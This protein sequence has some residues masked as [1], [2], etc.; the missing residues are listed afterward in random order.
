M[1]SSV[2]LLFVLVVG[3]IPSRGEQVHTRKVDEEWLQKKPLSLAVLDIHT[4]ENPIDPVFLQM[5]L[6]QALRELGYSET[7][8]QAYQRPQKPWKNREAAGVAQQT[9]HDAALVL[10]FHNEE[11]LLQASL[12]VI[13]T[14]GTIR[15]DVQLELSAEGLTGEDLILKLLSPLERIL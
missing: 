15:Y 1:K 12:R 7:R 6:A 5:N 9:G 11:G 3:C 13:D 14:S 8:S 2:A 10:A 4:N